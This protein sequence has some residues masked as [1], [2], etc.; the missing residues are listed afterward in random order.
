V[1]PRERVH[2]H[3]GQLLGVDDLRQ[4]Q[5]HLRSRHE[6]ASRALHG[7]G[8]VAGLHV[9]WDPDA[10]ELRV[11]PGVAVD[12][13]GRTIE[14]DDE[15][16]L[17]VSAWLADHPEVLGDG[18]ARDRGARAHL[19]LEL[20]HR[21]EP[22]GPVPVPGNEEATTSR[23][24]DGHAL[25]LRV[26]SVTAGDE[27]DD[28]PAVA[29]RLA[30][31]RIRAAL[32]RTSDPH[33]LGSTVRRELVTWVTS[34]APAFLASDGGHDV[35]AEDAAASTSSAIALATVGVRRR[36]RRHDPTSTLEVHVTEDD[37]PVLLTVDGLRVWL[38]AL[39][40]VDG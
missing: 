1:D 35:H 21:E 14:V 36:S 33:E 5:L 10:S 37:R 2:H 38:T 18:P 20:S 19:V 9:D 12:R 4:D 40:A 28:A 6:L 16:R 34:L 25:S 17:D 7:Y 23:I 32:D 15:Q 11:S 26:A 39:L 13:V 22:T 29:A 3:H 24:R 30:V 31:A 8:T 27:R